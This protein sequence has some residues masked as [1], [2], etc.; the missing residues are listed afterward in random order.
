MNEQSTLLR[1]LFLL[2]ILHLLLLLLI[3]SQ[4]NV[5]KPKSS[6]HSVAQTVAVED[7]NFLR[8]LSWE[9]SN[10][11]NVFRQNLLF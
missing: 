9:T 7:I 11:F 5:W 1:L 2:L 4:E 3:L 10:P 8:Q 6:R